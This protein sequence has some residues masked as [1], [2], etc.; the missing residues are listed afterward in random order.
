MNI[1][2]K[3]NKMPKMKTRS[4]AKKRFVVISKKSGTTKIKATQSG[5]QHGMT[6]RSKRHNRVQRG[7]VIMNSSDAKIVLKFLPYGKKKK[8]K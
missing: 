5:K 3:D 8:K 6:K 4:S 7:T 1:L 2:N